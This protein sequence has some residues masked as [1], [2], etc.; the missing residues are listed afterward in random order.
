MNQAIIFAG[1]TGQRMSNKGLPKQFLKINNKPILIHTLEYFQKHEEIDQ[2][3]LVSLPD[4][5]EYTLTLLEQYNI[6]KVLAI[7]DGGS[8]GQESIYHGLQRAIEEGNPTDIV[9]LHDGVRPLINNQLITDCI[10]SVKEKG[11]AITVA[12]AHETIFIKSKYTDQVGDIL[13]RNHCLVAKAPQCFY[14]GDILSAHKQAAAEN[15]DYFIDSATMMQHYGH[16]LFTVEG[17]IDN[18]KITTP[19]DLYTFKA[20]LEAR[21]NM[22]IMGM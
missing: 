22:Q 2:I 6:T 1:G 8:T 21:E 20:L 16:P 3:I 19:I 4:W 15:K 11:S 17:P 13:D 9:L 18:I 14:L 7:V 10:E 12:P 5:K